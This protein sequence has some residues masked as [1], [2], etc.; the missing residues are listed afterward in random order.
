MA[1]VWLL[2]ALCL[3]WQLRSTLCLQGMLNRHTHTIGHFRET[4]PARA[5]ASHI[6]KHSAHS[7]HSEEHG[8]H[9]RI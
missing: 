1:L 4:P 6:A 8:Q 7:G 2:T 9:F 3:G 5:L